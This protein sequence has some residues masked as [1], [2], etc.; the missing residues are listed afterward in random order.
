VGLLASN[1][2]ALYT[3]GVRR[4]FRPNAKGGAHGEDWARREPGQ[5]AIE[6]IADLV[7]QETT[8]VMQKIAVMTSSG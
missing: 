3:R 8:T 6:T 5:R 2:S 4:S 1:G 7:G